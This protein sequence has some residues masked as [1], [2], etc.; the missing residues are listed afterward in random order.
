MAGKW[1]GYLTVGGSIFI[2]AFFLLAATGSLEGHDGYETE[3]DENNPAVKGPEVEPA[4]EP[5]QPSVPWENIE[6]LN[7]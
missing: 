2:L 4:P 6:Q 7:E 5:S 3:S 1:A